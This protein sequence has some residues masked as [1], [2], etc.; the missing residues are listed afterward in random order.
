[1]LPILTTLGEVLDGLR[2]A[3]CVF[4]HDDATLAWNRSFLA[5]FPEHEPHLRVG[6]PYEANLRRFYASRLAPGET[7]RLERNVADGLARHRAQRRPFSFEHR[8]RTLTVSS[9]PLPGIGRIRV[10]REG[11]IAD[12]GGLVDAPAASAGAPSP[13]GLPP[14][15]ARL[16]DAV[17]EGLALTDP[18][19]R[20]LWVNEPFVLTYGLADRAAP[21]G[22]RLVDVLRDAALPGGASDDE[23]ALLEERVRFAGAPFDVPLA[24]DRCVQV[25]VQ[26]RRDGRSFSAH[27]DITPQRRQQRR[28]EDAERRV[29]EVAAQLHEKSSLLE[30]ALERM[31]QGVMMINAQRVVEVCNRRA[32]ELL[33]LSRELMASKPSF[34]R[35]LEHQWRRGEFAYSSEDVQAFVRAGGILDVAHRYE[36]RRPDGTV[37]EVH[38]VPIAGGGVLRTITDVTERKV[39]EEKMLDRARSDGLTRLLNREAFLGD[40]AASL[41]RARGTGAGGLAVL[42]VDLDGFK[43]VNDTHGHAVGD[44]VLVE[45]GTRLRRSVRAEDAVGR[46]GG[47]EF[48]VVQPGAD[49]PALAVRLARRVVEAICAPMLIEGRLVRVGASVGIALRAGDDDTADGLVRRADAAMYAAKAAG[50]GS[51]RLHVAGADA[52]PGGPPSPVD[53]RSP[54]RSSDRASA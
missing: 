15:V 19:D 14:E 27:V 41:A 22:C 4:D 20:I 17:P 26:P 9:L 34:E 23:I 43:A 25:T 2:I 46:L 32:T 6:E 24:G 50:T 18:Q 45:I 31:E 42:Y 3:M 30:A 13:D 39:H 49:Q 51:I 38:S 1:M 29:R 40:L 44:Q 52:A 21:L 53:A 12:P 48:V 36:R 35:V 10:W 28:A 37:I 11:A 7:D 33:G 16:L 47:D 5:L 8:G 54:A